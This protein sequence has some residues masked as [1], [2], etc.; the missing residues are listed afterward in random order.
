MVKRHLALSICIFESP[1]GS[2]GSIIIEN[3]RKVL[4]DSINASLN[5][6]SLSL[7]LKEVDVF[8]KRGAHSHGPSD[9]MHNPPQ[10]LKVAVCSSLLAVC[11]GLRALK[12]K[13][14]MESRANAIIHKSYLDT[15]SVIIKLAID[16]SVNNEKL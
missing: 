2:V 10:P 8:D 9:A 16:Y 11:S 7:F 3:M 6:Q 1:V 12:Q 15:F 5:G 13:C 4:S 14:T